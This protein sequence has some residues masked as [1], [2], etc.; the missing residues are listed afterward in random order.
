ME[1]DQAFNILVDPNHEGGY[2]AGDPGD[3]G[4]ETKYGI[5]KRAYPDLDI[6]GLTLDD[7]RAIYRRDYWDKG[8][9]DIMDPE[10]RYQA[11]DFAVNHGVEEMRKVVQRA[12]G[13]TVD[14]EWGDETKAAM[15][16][17]DGMGMAVR[18]TA[19]VLIDYTRADD[20]RTFGPVWVRRVATNLDMLA[21]AK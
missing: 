12:L 16:H 3:P 8:E 17:L 21:E 13:V 6:A 14:G 4:G 20:F 19:Q 10:A 15:A 5:S 1:F 11:F 2:T 18:L 9:I 7:A